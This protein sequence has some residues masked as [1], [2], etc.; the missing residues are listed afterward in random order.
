MLSHGE[1]AAP[2]R[3]GLARQ[4]SQAHTVVCDLC[5]RLW[6]A[7]LPRSRQFV[8]TGDRRA[9]LP[10]KR[11]REGT[12]AFAERPR[13]G[14]VRGS[15]SHRSEPTSCHVRDLLEVIHRRR[16]RHVGP[17]AADGPSRT[18]V[19]TGALTPGRG[20]SI[21]TGTRYRNRGKN[22]VTPACCALRI[23]RCSGAWSSRGR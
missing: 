4:Q 14:C 16:L 20:Q 3:D 12:I 7:C 13:A 9:S 21:A 23:G 5:D 22:Q 10:P 6:C 15:E 1:S 11:W 18:C 8:R 17:C 19:K 2:M